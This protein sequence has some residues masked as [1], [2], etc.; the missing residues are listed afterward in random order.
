[1]CINRFR[2]EALYDI[3]NLIVMRSNKAFTLIELLI[4]IG[5]I[6]IMSSIGVGYYFGYYKQTMLRSQADKISSFLYLVQQ[7]SIGQEGRTNWGIHFENPTSGT[8]YYASFQGTT[9]STPVE[10]IYL[11]GSLTYEYPAS[12]QSLDIVF[13][14]ITGRVY[15]NAYKKVYLKN[16]SNEGDKAIRVTPIG[17][18]AVDDGEVAWWK[19]NEGSGTLAVDNSVF[20]SNASFVGA[21][22][23]SP[24]T[25]CRGE[26]QCLTFAPGNYLSVGNAVPLQI[27]GNQTI[28]MWLY[29]T[30]FASRRNP[31]NKAYG[32][33]GT[34]TQETSGSL[35]Y[36]YGTYGGDGGSYQGFGSTPIVINTWSHVAIVR[37]LTN[38]KLYWYINGKQVA[39][40][41]ATYAAAVSGTNSVYIGHGYAGDY[42]GRI[43]D[44]RV[45]DRAL[46]PAE[47]KRAYELTKQ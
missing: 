32:G 34:I 19:L 36:Y 6:A 3:I 16:T 2:Y 26:G 22:T 21:P 15:D 23:W 46:T 12:G 11:D 18:I 10:K 8:P 33:E 47:V 40:T 29:P 42:A 41:N 9:Y 28:M 43:D 38:M 5:I 39:A 24:L 13:S 44:V 1:M 27:T 37:D 45:F 20:R 30:S 31:Y 35:S 7:K 25:D 14:K 17:V 4:V